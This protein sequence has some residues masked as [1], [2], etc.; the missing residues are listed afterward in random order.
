MGKHIWG[1]SLQDDQGQVRNVEFKANWRPADADGNDSRA[2]ALVANACVAMENVAKGRQHA[3]TAVTY[4][5]RQ[6]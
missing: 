4:K 1:I 5:G 3:V 2:K 6:K